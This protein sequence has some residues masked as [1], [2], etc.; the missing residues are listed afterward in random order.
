[1]SDG[2]RGDPVDVAAARFDRRRV[3]VVA[4]E[5]RDERRDIALAT[6]DDLR[7]IETGRRVGDRGLRRN[8]AVC[9]PDASHEL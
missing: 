6:Q 5:L 1:M 8:D 3:V 4:V 7:A 2:A 9:V